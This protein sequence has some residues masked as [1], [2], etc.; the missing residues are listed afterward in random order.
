M[1]ARRSLLGGVLFLFLALPG[2][3]ESRDGELDLVAIE[4]RIDEMR[5]R[6]HSLAK[7][8][9][10]DTTELDQVRARVVARGRAYYRL[11]RGMPEGDFFEHAVRLERLRQ[12]LLSDMKRVQSLSQESQGFD[13][14]LSLLRERRVP[15]EAEKNA[16]G[17]ARDALLSQQEREQA[18]EQAFSSLTRAPDHTAVYSATSSLESASNF[19]SMRGRLPFPVPGR[20]EIEEVRRPFARG[21]GLIFHAASTAPVRAVFAGRVAYASEYAEYGRA[22]I[23]DHG[24][25]FFTVSAGLSAID[26]EVGDE[27]P[28]GTRIGALG[29]RGGR[30]ELYFELRRSDETVPPREWFGI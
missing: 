27:I 11:S 26:V 8:I 18:F 3:T 20:T 12:G 4:R 5:R 21:P 6:E 19:G 22:V 13:H 15:L 1:R 24:E 23:L 29:V 17:R 16:A 14:Q 28:T 25:G 2:H 7:M 10:R 9:E 30:G